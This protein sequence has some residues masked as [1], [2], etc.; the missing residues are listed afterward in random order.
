VGTPGTDPPGTLPTRTDTTM[1]QLIL[2]AHDV[3]EAWENHTLDLE[4]TILR[5]AEVLKA[6]NAE[7][8]E[9]TPEAPELTAATV[10]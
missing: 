7:L 5:L 3:V 6:P 10:G 9:D 8:P 4:V 1:D 2:A